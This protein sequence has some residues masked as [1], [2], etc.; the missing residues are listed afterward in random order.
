M[1]ARPGKKA[2]VIIDRMEHT[3]GSYVAAYK[4][5]GLAGLRRGTSTG[6]PPKLTDE[7]QEELREIIAYK[8]PADV[9]CPASWS[10]GN[11]ARPIR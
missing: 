7:Q 11:G 3:V 1:K 6:K 2:A 9:G 5:N 4:K 8:T 10:N